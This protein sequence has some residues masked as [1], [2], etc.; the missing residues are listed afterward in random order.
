[1]EEVRSAG[2]EGGAEGVAIRSS[3]DDAL[4][5]SQ[6][7]LNLLAEAGRLLGSALDYEATL[8]DVCRLVVPTFADWCTLDLVAVYGALQRVEVAHKDPGRVALA[9]DLQRRYPPRVE[10]PRGLFHVLRTGEPSFAPEVTPEMLAASAQDDEHLRLLLSLG[11]RSA[12]IVPLK[13]RGR[14]LGAL[15]L[16]FAESGRRYDEDD[17]QL[18]TELAGRIGLAVDNARLYAEAQQA[19]QLREEALELHCRIEERLRLLVEASS[20]LSA[21]L[22]LND[23][24]AAVLRLSERLIA[25]DA[26]AVW[27][28]QPASGRWGIV[29]GAGLSD[30]YQQKTVEVVARSPRVPEHPV[31]AEDVLDH[32]FFEVRREAY[33]REGIRSTLLVPLCIRGELSGTLVFYYRE[34]HRFDAVEVAVATALSNLAGS[35]IGTAELYDEVRANDRRKDEFLAMLAHEL[36]NPLSAISNAANLILAFGPVSEPVPWGME[37]IGRQVQHLIR[38]IDDLLDVSRITRGKIRLRQV[39]VDVGAAI[40]G[41]LAAVRRLIEERGHRLEI[42]CEPGLSLEA[43][44]TRLEQI[45]VNLLTN[46]AKYT[47]PGGSI[48]LRAGRDTAANEVVIRVRDTGIGIP[49]EQLPRIFELFVQ[50]ERSL[51]RAEG[52][53]G[54]GLTV[55]RKLTEMHGGSVLAHSEGPGLGAEFVV[56]LPASRE[57]PMSGA[58]PAGRMGHS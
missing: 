40:S 47:E 37:V 1:M 42:A 13:A 58:D 19:V 5:R 28:H 33:R 6:Q 57:A 54:I 34:R 9:R 11:L 52:G 39:G 53:L 55:V 49:P 27:R 8:A 51:D 21:S 29:M 15:T 20:S 56:R 26:Y 3:S 31:I 18:G 36:R 25:A 14:T 7:R 43:D 46:A 38:L 24:A 45:V 30:E 22:D 32:P 4:R 44:P 17:L 2:H 41:A 50:G 12:M 16:I 48:A 23:V 10:S 35:A